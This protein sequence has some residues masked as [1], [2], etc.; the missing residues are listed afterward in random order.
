MGSELPA[1]PAPPK[2]YFCTTCQH[3]LSNKSINGFQVPDSSPEDT[4]LCQICLG[5]FTAD[6]TTPLQ[7]AIRPY[8]LQGDYFPNRIGQESPTIFLPGHVLQRFQHFCDNTNVSLSATAQQF[9]QLAMQHVRKQLDIIFDSSS[10]REKD[11][12]PPI[13]QKEEQGCLQIHVLFQPDAPPAGA[14]T[15]HTKRK[16]RRYEHHVPQGGDPRVHL[17]EQLAPWQ[18]WT[19]NQAVAD[20]SE[21]SLDLTPAVP[22]KIH[23]LCWRQAFYIKGAYTKVARNISQTP[24]FQRGQRLGVT[25]VSE[26]ISAG[27][28]DVVGGISTLHNL[29]TQHYGAISFHA[30]G[31]EDLNVRM[32]LPP[33]AQ[34]NVTGRPFVCAIYD[35]HGVPRDLSKIVQAINSKKEPVLE[36]D[37]ASHRY[38]GDNA[39]GISES[40]AY[41]PASSYSTL[42]SETESK[43][44]HYGCRCW[45]ETETFVLTQT[46][47]VTLDQATPIRVLHR[48]TNAIRQRQVLTCTLQVTK[49]HYFELHLSTQAGTYVKEF[50]HGDFGRTQPNMSSL[51]G[52]R[53][54]ILELDCEGIEM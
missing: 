44:K 19:I 47:P 2:S 43:V 33:V 18:P 12:L 38:Y 46:F 37:L 1:A 40:L 35:A 22:V 16:R 49:P 8:Q 17:Q 32:L 28:N 29:P 51:L 42:Q 25:S 21:G 10:A 36:T 26:E 53:T 24:F 27:I 50:V 45:S 6:L 54:D 20:L 7:E 52:C 30:S 4:R 13:L 14:S 23:G 41:T 11:S 31:R 3:L 15:S 34:V 39:V 48:R 5:V 9:K